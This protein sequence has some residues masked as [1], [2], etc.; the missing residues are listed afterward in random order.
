LLVI[1]SFFKD[2]YPWLYELTM[3]AYRALKNGNAKAAGETFMRLR[4]AIEFTMRG[5][6]SEDMMGSREMHMMLR[7][8]PMMLDHMLHMFEP[9]PQKPTSRRKP[10][11][12]TAP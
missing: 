1:A 11:K 5:P 2:D 8:L 6:F 12:E 9:K 3:D 4:R 10:T 7:E